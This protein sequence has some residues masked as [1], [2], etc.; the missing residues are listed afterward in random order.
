MEAKTDIHTQLTHTQHNTHT[1]TH[2][3]THIHKTYIHVHTHRNTF[4][5][6]FVHSLS[7]N[8]KQSEKRKYLNDANMLNAKDI[9]HLPSYY[10]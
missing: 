10:M 6:M 5:H 4:D 7:T 2:T 8:E 3:H 1:H 9:H